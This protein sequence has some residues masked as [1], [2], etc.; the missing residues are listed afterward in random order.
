V[1]AEGAAFILTAEEIPPLKNRDD[2]VDEQRKVLRD[3]RRLQGEAVA[4]AATDPFLDKVRELVR[5]AGELKSSG[6]P[7]E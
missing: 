5:V 7:R 2:V 4:R 3:G 6:K 1:V